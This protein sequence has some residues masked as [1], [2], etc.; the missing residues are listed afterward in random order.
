MTSQP[1]LRKR[2]TDDQDVPALDALQWQIE[3]VTSASSPVAALVLAAVRD[4]L[5]QGGTL[6]TVLPRDV[7][8]GDLI[9]LRVMAA[10]HR[11]A[12]ERRAPHVAMHLPTLGGTPPLTAMAQE[13]FRQAV[14]DSLAQNQE[15]LRASLARIPQTNETGRAAL[16]RCALSRMDLSMPVRLREVGASAGLNLRADHLPGNANLEAGPL[17]V[18]VERRGCDLNPV[19]PMRQDGRLTL[20]SYVWVDDVERFD[21]LSRALAV[22]AR[23]PAT[24]DVCEAGDFVEAVDTREGHTTVL[25]HSAMWLYLTS[26]SRS[27]SCRLPRP[28]GLGPPLRP[29][30]SMPRGNGQGSPSTSTIPSTWSCAGGVA[31][32]TTVP[33]RCSRMVRAMALPT[34]SMGCRDSHWAVSRSRS[35]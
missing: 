31:A 20:S 12:L 24:V 2:P 13:S 27:R 30:S 18:I 14:V 9:G 22:A 25:W 28:S 33:L 7:R 26:Q 29:R 6:A 5:G 4:D 21:R 15:V 19:D 35:E 1:V 17:P 23:V 8:F 16:L 34:S 11:L 10:V 3:Y 32:P